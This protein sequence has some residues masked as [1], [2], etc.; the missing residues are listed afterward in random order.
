[1]KWWKR[2]IKMYFW[3]KHVLLRQLPYFCKMS[4]NMKHRR[5]GWLSTSG[6]SNSNWSEGHILEKKMLCGPQFIRKK[7]LQAT[8][9]KKS[10]QNKLNLI[11]LFT[12]V[13]FWG[14]RGPHQCIRGP[15]AARSPHV[16]NPWFTS[17]STKKNYSKYLIFSWSFFQWMDDHLFIFFSSFF[18][19][20]ILFCPHFFLLIYILTLYSFLS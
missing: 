20:P 14:V 13:I 1:M 15:H 8:K 5:K 17:S 19:E 12:L 10:P 6:V 16:W 2:S 3:K 7:L 9:Y 18:P 4:V 11:K